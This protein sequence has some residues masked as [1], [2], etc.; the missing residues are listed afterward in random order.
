MRILLPL[1]LLLGLPVQ[2]ATLKV[3]VAA[4][5]KSTLEQV[6]AAWEAQTGN[7]V[8]IS[9]GATGALY[10][11]ILHG[12]PY[13]LFLAADDLRPAQLVAQGLASE[14]TLSDYAV[15]V[16]AFW[17][18]GGLADE[19]TLTHWSSRLAMANPRTAPYGAAAEQAAQHLDIL[20][21]LK[22]KV[23]RGNNI[24]HTFQ[25]VQSG[26]A[27]AGLVSLAQ[28]KAAGIPPQQYWLIPP[29]WHGSL[30][31]QGVVL[32]RSAHPEEAGALLEFLLAQNELLSQAGY[33]IP[34]DH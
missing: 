24:L 4:N 29:Q 16:L 30:T 31:Q 13:D 18:P 17:N 3:A 8:Q 11:K 25:Y 1:L 34:D 2:A 32:N 14:E 23:V 20:S 15:G 33:N 5:F 26:N 9:A 12:A 27:P 6:V 28:L 22:G 7:R 19:T 21:K 10:T